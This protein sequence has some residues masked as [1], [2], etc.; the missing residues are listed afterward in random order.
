MFALNS[1]FDLF[2]F[3][4]AVASK[5]Q[6]YQVA[7]N[8]LYNFTNFEPAAEG[9]GE[10][11]TDQSTN[12]SFRAMRSV[13]AVRAL[14]SVSQLSELKVFLVTLTSC[15]EK[16]ADAG[17]LVIF[18]IFVTSI[19][20]VQLFSGTLRNRCFDMHTGLLIA[21]TV[22]GL[23]EENC[24]VGAFCMSCGKNPS[25]GSADNVLE[26][27]ILVVASVTLAGWS[28]QMYAFMRA[29]GRPAAIFFIF[30]VFVL[31]MYLMNVFLAIVVNQLEQLKQS[32][33]QAMTGWAVGHW[34][35][36]DDIAPSFHTWKHWTKA[37]YRAIQ[38]HLQMKFQTR[39]YTHCNRLL[40]KVVMRIISLPM[41]RAMSALFAV[42]PQGEAV[43]W[44]LGR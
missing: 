22:C 1:V 28:R 40:R 25:S 35:R 43:A 44:L 10:A 38:D 3:A 19:A 6:P 32:N 31:A 4:Q 14:R 23:D 5:T 11:S 34:M 36:R 33:S 9:S 18:A 8:Y 16:I 24:P 7:R 27:I 42:A 29:S 12:G 37:K 2:Y 15:F 17:F 39:G 30:Q 20:G 21:D 41:A 26:G 13:R